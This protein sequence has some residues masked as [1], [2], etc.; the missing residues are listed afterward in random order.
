MSRIYQ[1]GFETINWLPIKE[2]CNQWVNSIAFKYFDNQCP[3]YLNEFFMKAP[4]SSSLLR[5]SYQNLQETFRETNTDQNA[6][7]FTGLSLWNKVPAEI[8][9]TTN[10]NAFKDNL[11][12]HYL[13]ELGKVS[14]SEKLSLII[15]LVWLWFYIVTNIITIIIIVAIIIL[16]FIIFIIVNTIAVCY[17]YYYYYYLFNCL[18]NFSC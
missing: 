9:R 11:K 7:S 18:F 14:F 16:L 8:K 10:L 6:L 2:R 13:K 12:K 17:Y 5:N 15:S 1:K 4:D 3:H